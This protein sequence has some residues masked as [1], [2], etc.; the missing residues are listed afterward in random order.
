MSQASLFMAP[1]VDMPVV[2]PAASIQ[3]GAK[4][5]APAAHPPAAQPQMTSKAL[6]SH[7]LCISASLTAAVVPPASGS[8]QFAM[9]ASSAAS[10]LLPSILSV[11]ADAI[12][13]PSVYEA[14]GAEALESL[15]TVGGNTSAGMKDVLDACRKLKDLGTK[16]KDRN[17]DPPS[18]DGWNT[19]LAKAIVDF[20][21]RTGTLAAD[22]NQNWGTMTLAEA[23]VLCYALDTCIDL[24][25]RFGYELFGQG[26]WHTLV[27]G[28][29]RAACLLARQIVDNKLLEQSAGTGD[30]K[31]GDKIAIV[32]YFSTGLQFEPPGK[33]GEALLHGSHKKYPERSVEVA[34]GTAIACLIKPGV[35]LEGRQIGKLMLSIA[36][37]VDVP[38]IPIDRDALASALS[39]WCKN[40]AVVAYRD[41]VNREATDYV[42][43]VAVDNLAEAARLFLQAGVIS[44]AQ[45]AD[46]VNRVAVLIASVQ[47]QSTPKP[48]AANRDSYIE[49]VQSACGEANGY[50]S[51]ALADAWRTLGLPARKKKH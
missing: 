33:G 50:P 15:Q 21:R 26:E 12:T 10:A 8:L 16:M 36:R 49:F 32:H 22:P 11:P 1:L 48:S 17:I 9:A 25:K 35:K 38:N 31:S 30:G 51:S 29:R 6:P 2:G 20:I 41:S 47:A 40:P 42:N 7:P 4:P 46:V 24:H 45:R 27:I 19:I 43:P 23:A 18:S 28:S 34:L 5:P 39:I 3:A 14:T 13:W 37:I 44:A